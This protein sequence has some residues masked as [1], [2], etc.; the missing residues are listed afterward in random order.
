MMLIGKANGKVVAKDAGKKGG[1]GKEDKK[2]EEE[3]KRMVK[4]QGVKGKI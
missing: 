1:K 3:E 2:E 4:V